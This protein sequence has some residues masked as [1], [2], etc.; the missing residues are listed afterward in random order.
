MVGGCLASVC[1]GSSVGHAQLA[2]LSVAELEVLIGKFVSV[3]RFSTGTIALGE[4]TA[5]LQN[6]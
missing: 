5:L 2:G 6:F 4:I 3:N 1:V